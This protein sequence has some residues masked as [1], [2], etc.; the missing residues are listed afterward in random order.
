M[1][2]RVIVGKRVEKFLEALAPE[3]RRKLWCAIK[4]LARDNGDIKQMEGRLAPTSRSRSRS[5]F[6]GGD[7]TLRCSR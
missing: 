5:V 3:P 4:E 2:T 1:K 6:E 7:F